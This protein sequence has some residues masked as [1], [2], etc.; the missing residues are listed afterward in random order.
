MKY[1][2]TGFGVSAALHAAMVLWALSLLWQETPE[3]TQETPAIQLSLAQFQTAPVPAAAPPP[4]QASEE[5]RPPAKPKPKP[6]EQPK[7]AKKPD[8]KQ[9]EKKPPKSVPKPTPKPVPKPE[10]KP[11]PVMAEAP[12]VVAPPA[13]RSAPA[14]VATRPA[15]PAVAA[16]SRP[17]AVATPSVNDHAA[18]NAYRAKLQR[19]IAARKQYPHQ[20]EDMEAEGTVVVAFTVMPNG[21]ITGVRVTKSAGNS[22][23]DK[24]AMQA[25]NAV[26][27]VLPFPPGINKARWD[28]SLS[29]NFSLE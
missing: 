15:S 10:K 9:V 17:A 4:V 26:S 19:L 5:P 24:A 21:A 25:V 20:A 13:P 23:L 3:N 28:F 11:E 1:H 18:E 7:P 2:L 6:V 27:G 14:P 12:A 29:V 16:S 8:K 22:W